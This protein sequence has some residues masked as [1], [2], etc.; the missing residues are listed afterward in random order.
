MK[1]RTLITLISLLLI[2]LLSA[3]ENT[4]VVTGTSQGIEESSAY[5]QAIINAKKKAIEEGLSLFLKSSSSVVQSGNAVSYTHL[6][7]P[8]KRIV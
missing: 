4:I 3:S 1:T 6:T 2:G 8:T 5:D 7:L